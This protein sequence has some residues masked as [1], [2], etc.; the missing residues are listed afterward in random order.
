MNGWRL[1]GEAGG[2]YLRSVSGARG[3]EGQLKTVAAKATFMCFL[4]IACSE[5]GQ[6]SA[7]LLFPSL[8]NQRCWSLGHRDHQA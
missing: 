1:S 2:M 5:A 4:L 7:I 6:S 3:L 8:A